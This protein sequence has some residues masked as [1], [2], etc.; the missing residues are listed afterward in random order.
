M[1][2]DKFPD[3]ENQLLDS[4]K[5]SITYLRISLT[6]RCNLRCIYCTPKDDHAKLAF[7]EL[8]TYEELLRIVSI[9][10]RLGI[11]KVRLTGGEP[12]LRR[13]VLS[14]IKRLT[15][16]PGL[17]DIRITTNGTC[18]TDFSRDLYTAGIRKLNISLDTLKPR[19]FEQISGAD[20]FSKVWSGIQEVKEQGFYT[21]KINMVVMRGVNDDELVDFGRLSIDEPFQVRFIEFMPI[22]EKTSWS[23]EMYM[24][25]EEIKKRL[26]SMGRLSPVKT[27]SMEGPARVYRFDGAAGAIGFISP[28]SHRFCSKCNRLRLTSEGRLRSCLLLDRETDLKAIL[29]SGGSDEDIKNVF[30]ETILNK[31]EGHTLQEG[32]P[33]N[34]HGRMSRIGG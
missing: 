18:L 29:R 2:Q 16:I 12:L 11:N 27:G 20:L 34:C 19:R 6:D 5:R 24:P 3:R 31:P 22:G 33:V 25:M 21:V 1:Q 13:N 8:L 4:F 15:A 17:N 10:V 30:I 7:G 14:F 9:A 23:N 32:N 28:V 26:E